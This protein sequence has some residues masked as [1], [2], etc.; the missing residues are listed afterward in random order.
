MRRPPLSLIRI[1]SPSPSPSPSR[2]HQATN[3]ALRRTAATDWSLRHPSRASTGSSNQRL[4]NNHSSC[5]ECLYIRVCFILRLWCTHRVRSTRLILCVH[6]V[7]RIRI[8]GHCSAVYGGREA[9]GLERPRTW[10]ALHGGG[11]VMPYFR[12]MRRDSRESPGVP[13]PSRARH[14]ARHRQSRPSHD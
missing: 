6:P 14:P 11:S 4:S 1:S 3:I 10:S 2:I 13:Q 8:L 7:T 5:S 9:H 12:G